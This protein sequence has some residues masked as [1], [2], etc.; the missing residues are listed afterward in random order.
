VQFERRTEASV[1]ARLLRP[2]FDQNFNHD[3]LF[4]LPLQGAGCPITKAGVFYFPPC[5]FPSC[6]TYEP[7]S[8]DGE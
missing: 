4:K 6:P 3:Y 2:D 7:N 5:P 1:Q 8:N